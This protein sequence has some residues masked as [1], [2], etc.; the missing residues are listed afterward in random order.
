MGRAS[1]EKMTGLTYEERT[2]RAKRRGFFNRIKSLFRINKP[3]PTR[4]ANVRR[5]GEAR[6]NP[7][8]IKES[9]DTHE[10]RSQSSAGQPG[11]K[12]TSSDHDVGS[13]PGKSSKNQEKRSTQ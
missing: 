11:D 3:K 6:V 7:A 4:F 10:I 5:H 12:T 2:Q 1:Q 8:L 13:D 9:Q